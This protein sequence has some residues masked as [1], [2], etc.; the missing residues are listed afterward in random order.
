MDE[1]RPLVNVP[2]DDA[3]VLLVG[4]LIGF[5]APWGPYCVLIIE[6]EHGAAKSSACRVVIYII[7]PRKAALRRPTKGDRDLMIA[8]TNCWVLGFDN[9]SGI[10]RDVSDSLCSLSTGGGFGTR[11][12]YTNDEEMLFDAMRPVVLNGIDGACFPAGLARPR[13]LHPP[14]AHPRREADDGDAAVRE[15]RRGT[16]PGTRRLAGRSS[17]RTP[18][19]RLRPAQPKASDG[20]LRIVGD[21]L[22]R[23]TGLAS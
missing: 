17:L 8:A 5:L 14:P 9:L 21:G 19:A 4:C 2:D 15:P 1:L 3:W 16:P 11:E 6:G 13:D 18:S 23:G 22:R 7:D 10:K 12:L 20:R